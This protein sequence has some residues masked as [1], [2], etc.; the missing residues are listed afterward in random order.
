MVKRLLVLA[1]V[2]LAVGVAEATAAPFTPA[3]EADYAFAAAWWGA[4]PTGCSSVTREMVPWA[5]IEA[6]G[7]ATQPSPWAAPAPC[8]FVIAEDLA[9][10]CLERET[11][12]HEYGHLLGYSHNEEPASIMNAQQLPGF[13]CR[14][15]RE[16]LARRNQEEGAALFRHR[17]KREVRRCR[18]L[19]PSKHRQECWLGVRQE[20]QA[21]I[22]LFG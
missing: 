4:T 5:Q 7:Q 15:E 3:L 1:A 8:V 6:N 18:H 11:V 10:P 17:L 20:R 12:L 2:L 22:A 14:E 16:A 19:R 21:Y 9:P 13:L